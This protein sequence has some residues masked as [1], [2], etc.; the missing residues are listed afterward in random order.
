MF[1]EADLSDAHGVDSLLNGLSYN[2]QM[3]FI[4]NEADI[5]P[6]IVTVPT[7]RTE[8]TDMTPNLVRYESMV[9]SHLRPM[10]ELAAEAF[11]A[12]EDTMTLQEIHYN[13]IRTSAEAGQRNRAGGDRY[14]LHGSAS[15]SLTIFQPLISSRMTISFGHPIAW[16][17]CRTYG[18]V[19]RSRH[20]V[21]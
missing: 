15:R 12:K 14:G 19:R 2:T 11:V 1:L 3:L 21:I 4:L 10:K 17:H 7:P 20:P 18:V 16:R 5:Q 8:S 13:R 9:S 6:G